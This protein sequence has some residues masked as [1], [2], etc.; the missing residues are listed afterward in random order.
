MTVISDNGIILGVNVSRDVI[1]VYEHGIQSVWPVRTIR[2]Q[3][4]LCRTASALARFFPAAIPG[5]H[6]EFRRW[7]RWSPGVG[8][9]LRW[10]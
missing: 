6:E 5:E 9:A 8:V 10:N 2:H 7:G 1:S 3:E 4:G